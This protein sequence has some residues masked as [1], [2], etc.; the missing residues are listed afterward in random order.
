[1]IFY[2]DSRLASARRP[3]AIMIMVLLCIVGLCGLLALA[4]EIGLVAVGRSQ[5]QNAA[6]AAALTG[7]RTINGDAADNYGL[8]AAPPNAVKAAHANSILGQIITGNSPAVTST[9][10]DAYSS[11]Q[12]A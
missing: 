2:N 9:G 4:I 12:V 3:G 1:M 11:G 8:G 10:T 6:D 5:A 7:A